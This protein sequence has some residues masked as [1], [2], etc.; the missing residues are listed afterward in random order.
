MSGIETPGKEAPELSTQEMSLEQTLDASAS[1]DNNCSANNLNTELVNFDNNYNLY[2]Q[3]L[4]YND[5][6]YYKYN[7]LYNLIIENVNNNYQEVLYYYFTFSSNKNKNF[8]SELYNKLLNNQPVT[9]KTKKRPSSFSKRDNSKR[10][11][12]R[13]LNTS[14][15][16]QEPAVVEG[17]VEGEEM[18]VEGQVEGVEGQVEGVEEEEDNIILNLEDLDKYKNIE[19]IENI[20]NTFIKYIDEIIEKENKNDLYDFDFLNIIKNN[21]SS[22]KIIQG[23]NQRKYNKKKIKGGETD[24][25]VKNFI[26]NNKIKLKIIDNLT[27]FFVCDIIHDIHSTRDSTAV[28]ND[29]K[30]YRDYDGKELLDINLD[31]SGLGENIKNYLQDKFRLNYDIIEEEI[32]NKIKSTPENICFEILQNI[33]ESKEYF[34]FY[35]YNF[36]PKGV[37]YKRRRDEIDDENDDEDKIKKIEFKESQYNYT[38]I[39]TIG[40]FKKYVINQ[41]LHTNY[42]N[43]FRPSIGTIIDSATTY[44]LKKF[45]SLKMQFIYPHDE[46]LKLEFYLLNTKV[47]PDVQKIYQELDNYEIKLNHI[48]KFKDEKFDITNQNN[49]ISL[50][51]NIN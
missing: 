3:E 36:N 25:Q 16:H 51:K 19:N 24:E 18:V 13:K 47:I 34:K 33:Y 5:N 11:V 30:K 8:L 50:L 9:P 38:Y 28:K 27:F 14:V 22:K 49:F 17:K 43:K 6:Y 40:Q 2:F 44:T 46:R 15:T 37:G 31:L 12:N 4:N 23:G 39:D 32:I 29:D 20:N 42:E 45:E 41:D 7:F 48:V 10:A 26:N 35:C 21:L 1:D